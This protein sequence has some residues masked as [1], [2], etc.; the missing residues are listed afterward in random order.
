MANSIA[1][2]YAETLLKIQNRVC[3]MLQR[4]IKSNNLKVQS[5]CEKK[6]KTLSH[7]PYSHVL[8]FG[9]LVENYYSV[10]IM[11]VNPGAERPAPKLG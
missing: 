7:N 9:I 8:K 6:K 1:L 5:L 2:P 3:I 10:P 4:K 11:A